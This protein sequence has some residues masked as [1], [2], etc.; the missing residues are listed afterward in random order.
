MYLS[1]RVGVRS[2]VIH[3]ITEEHL[4]D[5]QLTLPFGKVEALES[6]V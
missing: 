1:N 4:F 3:L 5:D 6:C 2:C